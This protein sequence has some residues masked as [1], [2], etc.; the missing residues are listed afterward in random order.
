[1]RTE[2]IAATNLS[3]AEKSEFENS[4]ANVVTTI[5]AGVVKGR[6]ICNVIKCVINL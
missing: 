2:V 6:L 1:M 3:I 4:V 5:G